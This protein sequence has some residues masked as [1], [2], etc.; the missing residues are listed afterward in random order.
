MIGSLRIAAEKHHAAGAFLGYRQTQN[1]PIEGLHFRQVSAK[2]ADVPQ[3]DHLCHGPS[4]RPLRPD[5]RTEPRLMA[6]PYSSRTCTVAACNSPDVIG[7]SSR[8]QVA[9]P[10][11]LALLRARAAGGGALLS[12]A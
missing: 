6:E 7:V 10:I 12:A 1:V 5:A 8:P 4:I 11:A 2:D 3:T 9:R